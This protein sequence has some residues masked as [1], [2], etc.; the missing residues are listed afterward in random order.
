MRNTLLSIAFTTVGLAM[1][2]AIGHAAPDGVFINGNVGRSSLSEGAIDDNDTGFGANI[3]YRWAVAPSALI[4]IEGGYTDLGEFRADAPASDLEAKVRGW[5]VG[6]NGHFNLSPNWYLSGRAGLFRAD[7]TADQMLADAT[8]RH[9]DDTTNSWYGG[10]GFGYD[11]SSNA[12]VG[13]NYDYYNVDEDDFDASPHLWS[14]SAEY[15][16]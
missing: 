15:R 9:I 2:P 4:G 1:I 5:N 6:A 16:F 7:L 12:S 11:F 3:G 8:I 10:V 14:V 13:L